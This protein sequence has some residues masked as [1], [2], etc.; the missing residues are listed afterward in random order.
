MNLMSIVTFVSLVMA[1]GNG[2]GMILMYWR[3][4]QVIRGAIM[5]V[6]ATKVGEVEIV[7]LLDRLSGLSR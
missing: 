2:L 3:Y 4:A 7:D 6:K 1:I 5:M